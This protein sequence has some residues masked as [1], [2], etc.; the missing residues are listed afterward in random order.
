MS[1]ILTKIKNVIAVTEGFYFEIRLDL[2][3]FV[4]RILLSKRTFIM[5]FYFTPSSP[6]TLPAS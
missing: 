3:V 2:K 5:N 1:L 6:S 4:K